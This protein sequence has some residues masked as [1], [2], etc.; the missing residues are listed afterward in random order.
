MGRT[1]SVEAVLDLRR[2]GGISLILPTE[3]GSSYA[4]E[5]I[6]EAKL[7]LNTF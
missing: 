6:Y 4:D 2:T 5:I 7:N 3:R 1:I